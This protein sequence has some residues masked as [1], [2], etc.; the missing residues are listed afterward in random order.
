MS[1]ERDFY[2]QVVPLFNGILGLANDRHI[3]G[4][5]NVTPE[6][7]IYAI[8][9]V[10]FED[11]LHVAGIV[12]RHIKRPVRFGAKKEYFDGEGIDGDGKFGRTVKWF[13]ENTHQIPV[14]RES[15]NPRSFVDLSKAVKSALDAGES[16]ALHA[17]GSRSLDGRLNK[18]KSGLARMAIEYGVPVGIAGLHYEDHPGPER[19]DVNVIFGDVIRPDEFPSSELPARQRAEILSDMAEE[20]VARLTGQER[21]HQ[22]A[23]FKRAA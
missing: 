6:P 3:I 20:R 21:S 23:D 12:A 7:K 17:E 10:R 19:T 18:F 13:M 16:V 1:S 15:T 11:S 5:E 8:N 22:F 2:M 14:E 4:L 9:H